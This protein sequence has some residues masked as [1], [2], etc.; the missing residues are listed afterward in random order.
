MVRIISI[1]DINI[2]IFIFSI[3]EFGSF[4]GL[5]RLGL[6]SVYFPQYMFSNYSD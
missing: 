6:K 3:W 2:L 1:G 4:L 5:N